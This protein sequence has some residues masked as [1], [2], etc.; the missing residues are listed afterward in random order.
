MKIGIAYSGGGARGIAHLGV[1]HAL[2]EVGIKPDFVS[3]TSAGAIVGALIAGGMQPKE[4]LKE[5]SS[6]SFLKYFRPAISWSGL[7]KLD[8]VEE[9]LTKFL[10][11][12]HFEDLNIPLVVAATDFLKGQSVLFD[13]GPLIKP[14]LA[15]SSIPFVFDPV[16]INGVQ[17]VDGGIM[18][19]LPV[20]PLLKKA[21]FVI[22]V[23]CNFS[24]AVSEFGSMRDILERSILLAISHNVEANRKSCDVFIDPP[25]LK[26][27][28]VYQV[29]KSKELFDIGYRFTIEMIEKEPGFQKILNT[30]T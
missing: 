11:G 5:L 20:Q 29:N 2:A 4:I 21:D 10:P 7:I 19:N 6:L 12:S 13:H 15:S 18:N 17:Y 3:G 26:D 8:K 1:T 9:V 16:E 23:N 14:I 27:Y 25:A 22:G 30:N 28:K 24:G